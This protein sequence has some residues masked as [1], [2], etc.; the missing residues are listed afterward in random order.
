L[1]RA[2]LGCSPG[3][4]LSGWLGGWLHRW[5]SGWLGG[6]LHRWLSGWLHRWHDRW[7]RWDGEVLYD[8]RRHPAQLGRH[9]RHGRPQL[10]GLALS[11]PDYLGGLVVSICDYLLGQ[12][13]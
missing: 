10:G 13:D 5:L 11:F 1:L 4:W 12:P 7:L 9:L 6:W 2:P 8:V 3:G